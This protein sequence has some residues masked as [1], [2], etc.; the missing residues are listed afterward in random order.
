[1][2]TSRGITLGKLISLLYEE[3]EADEYQIYLR[4]DKMLEIKISAKIKK[5]GDS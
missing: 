5:Q 4:D 2:T 3:D 1:M